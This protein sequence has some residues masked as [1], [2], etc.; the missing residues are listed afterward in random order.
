MIPATSVK[1]GTWPLFSEMMRKKTRRRLSAGVLC[2]IVTWSG[3]LAVPAMAG[4]AQVNKREIVKQA[5][6]ASYS[7]R[8]LGLLEFKANMQPNWTLTAKSFAPNPAAMRMLNAL[9]FSVSLGP[10]GSVKVEHSSSLPI[11]S[12]QEESIKQVYVGMDEIVSGFFATWNSFMLTSPFPAV[13]SEYQLQD[14][15]TAY[16]LTYKES[17][18]D[19][20]ITMNKNFSITELKVVTPEFNASIRPEFTKT[21]KGFVLIGYSA[22]YVPTKGPGKVGLKMDIDYQDVNGFR[23][24]QKL[25]AH[26]VY[27]GQ[28]T[29]TELIFKNYEVKTR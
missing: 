8:Q 24:P 6:Q 15:G 10:D 25:R 14:L 21:E 16:L 3:T 2:L 22:D 9:L 19:V 11:P 1:I 20:A 17:G 4:I 7:L 12:D 5:T 18:T 29:E 26:S 27:D 13:D 28:P 23:L